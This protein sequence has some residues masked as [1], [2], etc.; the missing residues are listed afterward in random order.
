MCSSDLDAYGLGLGALE[1]AVQILEQIA[2][3]FFLR[4]FQQVEFACHD[5]LSPIGWIVMIE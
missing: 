4:D 2:V 3:L 1:D 5:A